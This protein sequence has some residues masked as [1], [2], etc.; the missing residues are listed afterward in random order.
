MT[1]TC[2]TDTDKEAP[3]N[4]GP[5]DRNREA[6]VPSAD[7]SARDAVERAARTL[8]MLRA[9]SVRWPE[10]RVYAD[11]VASCVDRAEGYE[12]AAEDARTRVVEATRERDA[13]ASQALQRGVAPEDAE[14]AASE[15][16]E[17]AQADSERFTRYFRE[18]ARIAAAEAGKGDR[19]LKELRREAAPERLREGLRKLA[20]HRRETLE[21]V[22]AAR[23]K[24][25]QLPGLV[26]ALR[27]TANAADTELAALVSGD[28]TFDPY[29][30][31]PGSNT[32]T[33]EM[34]LQELDNVVHRLDFRGSSN[35]PDIGSGVGAAV[36]YALEHDNAED[37]D[38]AIRAERA[39]HFR[40]VQSGRRPVG[41]FRPRP[42]TGE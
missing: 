42:Y 17:V 24:L 33:Y 12:I 10:L 37:A 9:A 29:G 32:L 19:R 6:Y 8:G 11:A 26:F 21:A 40:E 1:T 35:P 3:M 38:A 28:N 14:R 16:L 31:R 25:A 36:R 2:E 34:V 30:R 18:A 39:E 23:A 41:P 5:N 4:P 15:A 20:D 7:A 22:A 27:A 13:A